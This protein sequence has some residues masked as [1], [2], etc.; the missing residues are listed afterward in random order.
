MCWNNPA[1]PLE[2]LTAQGHRPDSRVAIAT[3]VDALP[4]GPYF[5]KT[6]VMSL[7]IF[8]VPFFCP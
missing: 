3:A 6:Q 7:R 5:S 2:L 8:A 4:G 1:H